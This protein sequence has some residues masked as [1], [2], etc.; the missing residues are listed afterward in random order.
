MVG[1]L[2]ELR[3]MTDGGATGVDDNIRERI[4]PQLQ[5]FLVIF[6]QY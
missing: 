3:P 1:Q 5:E 2:F 4:L 6:T